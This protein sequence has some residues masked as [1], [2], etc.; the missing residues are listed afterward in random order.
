M[1]DKGIKGG[2]PCLCLLCVSLA[3]IGGFGGTRYRWPIIRQRDAVRAHLPKVSQQIS[4]AV[5]ALGYS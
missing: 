3:A 1:I 2:L 5:Y 4:L